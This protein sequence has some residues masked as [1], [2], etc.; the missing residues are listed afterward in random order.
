MFTPAELLSLFSRHNNSENFKF[1]CLDKWST[2]E[3]CFIHNIIED[4][5]ILCDEND[6][7]C[8]N[9]KLWDIDFEGTGNSCRY[10]IISAEQ[11]DNY[12]RI[13]SNQNNL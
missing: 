5:Y 8:I 4:N 2:S 9:N 11:F 7:I 10:L 6:L 13:K 1:I 3:G 12:F